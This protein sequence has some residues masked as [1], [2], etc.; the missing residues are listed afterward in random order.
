MSAARQWFAAAVPPEGL[1]PPPAT[2]EE[3][4][5]R[6]QEI[7]ARQEFQPQPKTLYQRALDFLSNQLDKILRV[8]LGGGRGSIVG[9]LILVVFLAA[10]VYFVVRM[11]RT[12]SVVLP[13]R[14][15]AGASTE[16]A[17]PAEDWRAEAAKHEANG[18]WR[19]AL[20]CRYRALVAD[21][22]ARGFVEEV[23]GR[24]AGEY[25]REVA[26][27]TPFAAPDFTDA[28]AM[29]ERAWYGNQPTAADDDARFRSLSERVLE[30]VG[31]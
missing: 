19:A 13:R 20:R 27:N 21:L 29:F 25:R 2:T 16:G 22:A 4:R 8:L 18:D 23:P 9:W 17:R 10:I 7:L 5:R 14:R 12:N 24:T 31:T 15:D 30:R 11:F 26:Q 28:T 1:R 6:T 3:I